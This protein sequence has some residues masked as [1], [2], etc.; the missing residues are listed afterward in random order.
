MHPVARKRLRKMLEF[1]QT[2]DEW[3]GQM[4]SLPKSKLKTLISLGTKVVKYIPLGKG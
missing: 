4:L 2:V 1:T 3:H